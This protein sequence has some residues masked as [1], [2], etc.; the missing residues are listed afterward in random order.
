MVKVCMILIILIYLDEKTIAHVPQNIYLVEGSIAENIAFEEN[1]NKE[2]MQDIEE[3]AEKAKIL[4]F[5]R[6]TD[7]GF[8]T[9]V[10]ERGINLSGGQRQ[11][12]AIARALFRKKESFNS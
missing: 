8:Q 5:I 2:R 11:R 3:A 12:I 7:K 9:N 10:G 6:K 4:N 1:F